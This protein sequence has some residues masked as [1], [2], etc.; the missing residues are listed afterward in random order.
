MRLSVPFEPS[1]PKASR[2]EPSR[3]GYGPVLSPAADQES[4]SRISL[5]RSAISL[6]AL[7][8]HSEGFSSGL[9]RFLE[10]VRARFFLLTTL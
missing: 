1:M 6:L 10:E 8:S 7:R 5:F 2:S 3:I 4:L 9:A